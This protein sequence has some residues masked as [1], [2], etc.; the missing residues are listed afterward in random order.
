MLLARYGYCCPFEAND[1]RCGQAAFTTDIAYA[2]AMLLSTRKQNEQRIETAFELA[3]IT[4]MGIIIKTYER[5]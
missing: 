4:R 2:V 5:A 3:R 1:E